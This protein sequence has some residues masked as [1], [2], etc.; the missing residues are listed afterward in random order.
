MLCGYI[1]V[2]LLAASTSYSCPSPFKILIS[3]GVDNIK[4]TFKI[5]CKLCD[6][7][8]LYHPIVF[9]LDLLLFNSLA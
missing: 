7:F 2:G 5:K 6:F 9:K 4:C 1:S 3:C 8:V